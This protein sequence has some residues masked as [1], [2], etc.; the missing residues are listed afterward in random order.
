MIHTLEYA[1]KAI[2]N[3]GVITL[4]LRG[5]A[6]AV[7]ISQRKIP[8]K[9]YDQDACSQSLSSR[10]FAITPKIGMVCA[11]SLPDAR[12]LVAR[13]RQEAA[14]FQYQY[15]YECPVDHVAR[16]LA[17]LAQLATQEAAMR[18]LAVSA[19]LAGWDEERKVVAVHRVDPA[20]FYTGYWGVASGPKATEATTALEKVQIEGKGFGA[21][22]EQII[23]C[24]LR[25]LQK[26]LGQRVAPDE[27]EVAV[28]DA[29]G[30]SVLP[31]NQVTLIVDQIDRE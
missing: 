21:T 13:A 10:L 1:F 8:D 19:T 26:V 25:V 14:S 12:T 27:V 11:G 31:L 22:T 29:E 3:E 2:S 24:G 4:G 30:F 23:K 7:L 20:G 9:L 18:P 6:S 17:N 5:D 16:R 28:C 15:G